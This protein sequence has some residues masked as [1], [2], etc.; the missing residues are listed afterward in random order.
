[1][2]EEN[3]IHERERDADL[4]RIARVVAAEVLA[5][6]GAAATNLTNVASAAA[7]T[8]AET[9]KLDLGYIKAD[10]IEIKALLVKMPDKFISVDSFTPVKNIVYG[11]VALILTGVIAGLLALVLRK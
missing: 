5:T 4:K 3:S 2:V 1:M 10:I 11:L 7:Q 9:T 6:A 8:L